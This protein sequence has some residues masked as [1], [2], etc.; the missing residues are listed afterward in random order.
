MVSLP[1][2]LHITAKLIQPVGLED[3]DD[4]SRY[5]CGAVCAL[6]GF[7]ECSSPT[8]SQLK[9]STARQLISLTGVWSAGKYF[10]KPKWLCSV[11]SM[12]LGVIPS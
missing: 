10:A 4:Y 3:A 1:L 2:L 6:E 11:D 5:Q 7:G 9:F 12:Q 8:R